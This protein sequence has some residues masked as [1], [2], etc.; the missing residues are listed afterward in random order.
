MKGAP[1][2]DL[3][4]KHGTNA[5]F[6]KTGPPL[7][8]GVKS[9]GKMAGNFIKGQGPLG[10]MNPV[11]MAANQ[12]QV[13]NQDAV[14]QNQNAVPQTTVPPTA[15][16]PVPT[17]EEQGVAPTTMK[18]K[19][20]APMVKIVKPDL[21]VKKGRKPQPIPL[22]PSKPL[23]SKRKNPMTKKGGVADY[24][25]VTNKPVET[26]KINKNKGTLK[27]NSYKPRESVLETTRRLEKE[28]H[29]DKPRKHFFSKTEEK[30][31]APLMR[32][33]NA[34][35][36]KNSLPPLI[37]IGGKGRKR[38]RAESQARYDKYVAESTASENARKANN[39]ANKK[40]T[41]KTSGKKV[42]Q[43]VEAKTSEV[44]SGLKP[45][46]SMKKSPMEKG[47]GDGCGGNFKVNKPGT[48]VSRALKRA[49]GSVK[50]G[51]DNVV[52]NIKKGNKKRKKK[53]NTVKAKDTGGNGHI[54]RS[55]NSYN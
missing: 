37:N 49:G 23:K 39:E 32:R 33:R 28:G 47:P 38:K 42:A 30:P 20:G 11:G 6:K 44:K 1:K 16:A 21:K 31:G 43:F 36:T 34:K 40:T 35:G 26:N 13:Q 53:R 25:R 27:D 17:P 5:N 7:M 10:F 15:G 48:V 46:A 14:A 50:R 3:S 45:G 22:K 54:V 51:L 24:L 52:G 9:L 8:K 4:S 29:F 18:K 19:A 55:S 2:H 12:N 41:S